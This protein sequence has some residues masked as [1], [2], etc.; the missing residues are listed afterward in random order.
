LRA[1][2]AELTVGIRTFRNKGMRTSSLGLTMVL[3]AGESGLTGHDVA[4]LKLEI[5]SGE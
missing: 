1:A 5:S 4:G 3:L 2:S